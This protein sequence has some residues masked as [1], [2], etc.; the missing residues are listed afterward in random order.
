MRATGYMLNLEAIGRFTYALFWITREIRVHKRSG[1]LP[2][3][4]GTI[5]FMDIQYDSSKLGPAKCCI[6][7]CFAVPL[8]LSVNDSLSRDVPAF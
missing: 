5:S 7:L 1:L 4:G 6:C 3:G 2:F 8:F